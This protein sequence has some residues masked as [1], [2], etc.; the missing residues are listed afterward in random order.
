MANISYLRSLKIF[1]FMKFIRCYKILNS[2]KNFFAIFYIVYS[3]KSINQAFCMI[4]NHI[5][6]VYI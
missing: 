2:K 1:T 5:L 3:I 6:S 4:N